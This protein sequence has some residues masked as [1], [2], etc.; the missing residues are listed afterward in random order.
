M[1]EDQ[2][3]K[4]KFVRNLEGSNKFVENLEENKIINYNFNSRSGK[5][6][7]VRNKLF[8][9]SSSLKTRQFIART[10]IL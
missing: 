4:Y 10:S 1:N 2:F 8:F 7:Y 3:L 6:M 5:R 9:F